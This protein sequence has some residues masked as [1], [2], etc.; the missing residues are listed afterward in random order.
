MEL[1]IPCPYTPSYR[2]VGQH[3]VCYLV[4]CSAE[5]STSTDTVERHL[6]G[7][8]ETARHPDTQKIRIIGFFFGNRLNWRFEGR[9]LV[10]MACTCV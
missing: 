2:I 5:S 6:S 1:Q 8:S 4:T 9:L 3:F 10:F 7:L